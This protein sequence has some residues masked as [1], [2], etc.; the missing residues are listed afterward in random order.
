MQY[1]ISN[2]L[3]LSSIYGDLLWCFCALGRG[4]AHR[5][6]LFPGIQ[7]PSD[8]TSRW[9]PLSSANASYC[10]VRSGLSPPSSY[11]CWVHQKKRRA[12]VLIACQLAGYLF[13]N[14]RRYHAGDISAVD[15]DFLYHAG[16]QKRI[17][18]PRDQQHR[19]DSVIEIHVGC[20]LQ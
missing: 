3:A 8:S 4:F 19:F 12:C 6:S 18:R 9:T 15:A 1:W 10:Q 17:F 5:V 7:L 14:F 11:P 13:E 2:C 20:R 16:A